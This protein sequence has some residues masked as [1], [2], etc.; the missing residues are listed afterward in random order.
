MVRRRQSGNG[1]KIPAFKLFR[2]FVKEQVHEESVGFDISSSFITL[3]L[4]LRSF[5]ER[6]RDCSEV[7]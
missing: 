2:L 3:S 5:Q 6:D 1:S 7:G 4:F